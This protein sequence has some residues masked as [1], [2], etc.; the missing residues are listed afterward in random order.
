VPEFPE[1][2]RPTISP[3]PKARKY[4]MSAPYHDD[5]FK[6][7]VTYAHQDKLPKLPI[8]DLEQ[9]CEK[10]LTAVKPLQSGREHAE[11][12][13]AVQE[14]LRNEGPELNE[15]LKNYAEGQTSYIEQFCMSSTLVQSQ[16][17]IIVAANSVNQGTTRTS[18]LT[19]RLF[20]T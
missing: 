12:R 10:Y 1:L 17:S 16:S 8:P 18:T 19:T 4:A 2:P 13:H 15:K 11:T 6:G 20:S 7:G 14:F 5:K 9:S 3:T